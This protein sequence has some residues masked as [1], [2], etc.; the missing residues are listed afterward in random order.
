VRRS[1]AAKSAG[2]NR[3]GE[4][5]REGERMPMRENGGLTCVFVIISMSL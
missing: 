3:A 4:V 5:V 1:G 2:R